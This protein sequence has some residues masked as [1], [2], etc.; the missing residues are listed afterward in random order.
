MNPDQISKNANNLKVK[1]A[2]AGRGLFAICKLPKNEFIIEYK[3][4]PLSEN[5]KY[6][7]TSKYLFEVNDKITL[8]GYIKNNNAKFINHSCKP[9][10]EF[11]LKKDQ[12]FVKTL[13]KIDSGQEITLNY[14]PEYFEEYIKPIGCKCETCLSKKLKVN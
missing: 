2:K 9:N 4:R 11:V 3:G 6:S 10:S 1:K 12:V 14:G 13:K 7:S 5:E 8:D